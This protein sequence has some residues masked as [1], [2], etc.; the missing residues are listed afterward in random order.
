M[1]GTRVMEGELL[2]AFV[3]ALRESFDAV[4]ARVGVAHVAGYGVLSNDTGT[5]FTPVAAGPGEPRFDPEE[6]GE[7][8]PGQALDAARALIDRFYEDCE[9]DDND[10]HWHEEFRSRVYQLQV[11]AMEQLLHEEGYF[12]VHPSARAAF[13]IVWIVDSTL[14]DLRGRAWCRRLND[15]DTHRSFIEWLDARFA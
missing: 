4:R 7:Y 6:W 15:E 14:P 5:A 3:A 9:D 10:G 12:D 13:R 8:N 11:R 1:N 2:Q